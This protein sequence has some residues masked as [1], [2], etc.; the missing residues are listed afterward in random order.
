M[1][2]SR[3]ELGRDSAARTGARTSSPFCLGID[4]GTGSLKLTAYPAR[5]FNG[6]T[7]ASGGHADPKTGPR[8]GASAAGAIRE[9]A[10]PGFSAQRAYPILSP[11]PGVAET[12]PEAWIGALRTA[13]LDV[14]AQMVG[15]GLAPELV[16]IGLSGQMHGFVPIGR[17]GRALHRAITWADERGAEFATMYA[18]ALGSEFGRLLNAPAA[19]LTALTLLWMK[20]RAPELYRDTATILFPKDYLRYRLTGERGTD[21]GDASASLL[22]DFSTRAWSERALEALCLD[23]NKLP[24]VLDSFSVG[25]TV[26]RQG[27]RDT[28]LSEGIPVSVGSADKACEL[29]GSGF[30]RE[31]FERAIVTGM[32]D[33]TRKHVAEGSSTS[34][35]LNA[36]GDP[37][38][39]WE[40]PRVV[41]VSIGTGIQVV[42]PTRELPPYAPGLN[43]FETCAPGLRYRMAA[44]LNGGLALE[45]VRS[46]LQSEWAEF[47]GDL[48][49]GRAELPRD[50]IFLPY[51]SGERSPYQNPQARGAWVGLALHHT[52]SDLL[53]SALL[54]VAC[55]IRLGIDTLGVAPDARVYC[56][57]GSTRFVPWMQIVSAMTGRPL[58]IS[59]E[60]DASVR[61]AAAIGL[62]A[63]RS[64]A[65]GEL[66]VDPPPPLKTSS[67]ETPHS[68]WMDEYYHQFLKYY[69]A[70]FGQLQSSETP[71]SP[72][73]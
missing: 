64:I 69:S 24:R 58:F 71:I 59:D 34:A 29:Y 61:G 44:M 26:C 54:G 1:L 31:Y 70:L 45:W 7:G 67:V 21:P 14:R 28:G 46:T 62:T 17:D 41:Q 19:G 16:S 53:A 63:V 57:G 3:E 15:A 68:S 72:S 39:D 50:L 23:V 27:A 38:T 73:V 6:R 5:I 66:Q 2:T 8:G 30:F 40:S 52:R 51:L 33:T 35:T 20:H 37:D 56:V 48:E 42:I 47:Y 9:S 10:A 65:H 60:P 18:A 12:D 43:L 25:G 13:W 49:H 55:T 11:A 32:P 22:W 4:L 36:C